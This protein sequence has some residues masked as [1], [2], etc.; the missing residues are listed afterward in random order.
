[1]NDKAF[2][3]VTT[4]GCLVAEYVCLSV[5]MLKQG[6][7]IYSLLL[8]SLSHNSY[9]MLLT[10]GIVGSICKISLMTICRVL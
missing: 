10:C 8:V 7:Q 3:C 1:M 4:I 2:Q 9:L 5:C 6:K